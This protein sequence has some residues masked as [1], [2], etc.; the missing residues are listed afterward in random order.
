M[1]IPQTPQPAPGYWTPN[2]APR[3]GT[4][5]GMRVNY[6]ALTGL[7]V[8]VSGFIFNLGI[9]GVVGIIF[10]IL[11]LREARR[12]AE[13]GQQSTGRQLALAG[14]I[15]GIAHI[16]VTIG[17]VVLS[18]FAVYWF[19]DWVNT[20]TTEIQNSSLNSFSSSF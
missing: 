1:T 17:L 6:M 14:I 4:S 11:G 9:N 12:L 15:I 19:T 13:A 2:V 20:L 18:I 7:L 3:L 8:S 5:A 16:I 10:S